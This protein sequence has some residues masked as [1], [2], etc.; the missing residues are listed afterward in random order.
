MPATMETK[1]RR[2]SKAQPKKVCLHCHVSRP[3]TEYYANR[4]WKEM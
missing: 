3:L 1:S 4:D 2:F